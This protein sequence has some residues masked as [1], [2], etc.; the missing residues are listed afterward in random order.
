ML[1]NAYKS[2]LYTALKKGFGQLLIPVCLWLFA[3][4]S[5]ASFVNSN[6]IGEFDFKALVAVSFIKKFE[7]ESTLNINKNHT[8]NS[9][10]KMTISPAKYNM[11]QPNQMTGNWRLL[12]NGKIRA[13]IYQK[14]L[15]GKICKF[16]GL[17]TCII[18]VVADLKFTNNNSFSLG[19]SPATITVFDTNS[20]SVGKRLPVKLAII[21]KRSS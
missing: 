6:Y 20:K 16:A 18:R 2:W 19:S 4:A 5:Q 7:L 17:E 3:S 11:G 1:R 15:G 8:L 14:I 9:S 21:G 13:V 12:S 10:G